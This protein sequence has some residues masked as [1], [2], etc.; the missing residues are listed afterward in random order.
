MKIFLTALIIIVVFALGLMSYLG[1][2]P[3]IPVGYKN[4][5]LI[6][7]KFYCADVCPNYGKWEKAYSGDISREECV[8]LKG[9]PIYVGLIYPGNPDI[10]YAGCAVK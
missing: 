5:H 10:G 3:D 6:V 1:H 8:T 7:Y 4:G 2:S 9:N